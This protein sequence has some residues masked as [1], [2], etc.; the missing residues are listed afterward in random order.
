MKV[1][2][3]F[4]RLIQHYKFS[5]LCQFPPLSH[6]PYDKLHTLLKFPNLDHITRDKNEELSPPKSRSDA[7]WHQ[8]SFF[9]LFLIQTTRLWKRWVL[10][11]VPSCGDVWQGGDK[12]AACAAVRWVPTWQGHTGSGEESTKLSV[13]LHSTK[14]S[15][16]PAWLRN[17]NSL[18]WDLFAPGWGKE[19]LFS[20]NIPVK[21]L[22]TGHK[23]S[24]L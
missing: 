23:F 10:G 11:S 7:S 3:C 15:M 1:H 4:I 5:I 6:K 14:S 19:S 12:Q 24:V 2:H 9:F 20:P 21:G 13:C 22:Q 18:S 8:D 17:S 16:V